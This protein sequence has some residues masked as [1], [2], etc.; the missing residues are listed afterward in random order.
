MSHNSEIRQH[1][2]HS[3]KQ[4]PNRRK[5]FLFFFFNKNPKQIVKF[6]GLYFSF[7]EKKNNRQN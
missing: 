1:D 2:L 7:K 4:A 5:P 6:P 3:D